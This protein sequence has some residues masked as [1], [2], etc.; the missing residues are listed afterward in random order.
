M[1]DKMQALLNEMR[2]QRAALELP[3]LLQRDF[4]PAITADTSTTTNNNKPVMRIMQWNLL[5]QGILCELCSNA[6]NSAV[7]YISAQ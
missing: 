3:A 4:Q 6:V 1:T 7:K 2:Q 5:A